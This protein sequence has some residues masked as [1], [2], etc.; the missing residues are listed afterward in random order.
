MKTNSRK[1]R[2]IVKDINGKEIKVGQLAIVLSRY[3]A[4]Y[5][6]VE[7][8]EETYVLKDLEHLTD[9]SVLSVEIIEKENE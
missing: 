1:E 7:E 3:Y 2:G 8:Q 6:N 5:G 9:G 4:G